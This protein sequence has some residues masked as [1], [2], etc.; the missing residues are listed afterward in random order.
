MERDLYR[1]ESETVDSFGENIELVV[2]DSL[3]DALKSFLK[4]NKETGDNPLVSINVR[5]EDSVIVVP[6]AAK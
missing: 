5:L 6:S 1:I 2:A 4:R 3:T